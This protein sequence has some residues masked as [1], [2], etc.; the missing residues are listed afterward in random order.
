MAGRTRPCPGATAPPGPRPRPS[1][2]DTAY[3]SWICRRRSGAVHAMFLPGPVGLAQCLAQQLADPALG[4][5]LLGELDPARLLVGPEPRADQ[6]EDLLGGDRRRRRH[7]THGHRRLAPA[8][9]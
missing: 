8:L 7:V 1:T 6:L 3:L 9:V 2:S 4:Q 5:R